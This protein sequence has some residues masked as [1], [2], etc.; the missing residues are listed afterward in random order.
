MS[1]WINPE[2]QKEIYVCKVVLRQNLRV[3]IQ[4]AHCEKP[5]SR[6][7]GAWWHARKLSGSS[8]LCLRKATAV[9][10]L[11]MSHLFLYYEIKFSKN[12]IQIVHMQA[13]LLVNTLGWRRSNLQS[14]QQGRNQGK[15]LSYPAVKSWG[16]CFPLFYAPKSPGKISPESLLQHQQAQ[17]RPWL[18]WAEQLGLCWISEA[19]WGLNKF[20]IHFTS[21]NYPGAHLKRLHHKT[22]CPTSDW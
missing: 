9:Q 3:Y 22:P 17:H 12:Y 13:V 14:S 7:G 5:C 11:L 2:F 20:R 6:R 10:F 8:L 21:L 19:V 15:I 1:I 4:N 18:S 16:K